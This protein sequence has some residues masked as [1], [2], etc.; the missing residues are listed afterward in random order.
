[1]LAL[2]LGQRRGLAVATDAL[3][4][5]R[6]TRSQGGLRR[7]QRL[8]NLAGAIIVPE[9]RRALV[10]GRRVLLID[11]VVTT[12][13]TVEACSRALLKAGAAQVGVLALAR[14][15]TAEN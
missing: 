15:F 12:G 5:T 4:R 11:D 8:T 7:R 1:M 13:A 6:R 14:V 3:L 2:A 10:A 9:A